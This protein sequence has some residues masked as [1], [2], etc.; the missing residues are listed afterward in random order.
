M[1]RKILNISS[2]VLLAAFIGVS[3]WFAETRMRQQTFKALQVIVAD[4]LEARFILPTDVTG[5]LANRGIRITGTPVESLNRDQVRQTVK[6]VTGVKDALVYCTPGGTLFITVWQRK[7]VLRYIGPYESFYIDTE[8]KEMA[9]SDKY[10]AKVMTVTG[11]ADHKFL[12][13]SL[14]RVVRYISGETFLDALIT[15][16]QVY[17]DHT[18]EI[19][20][21]IG[22]NRIFMGD[23]GDYEWKLAKLRAFYRQ[24]LPNV[25]WD[26]YSRIDLA[27]S[28]Q[29][30]ARLWTQEQRKERDSLRSVRDTL[31]EG[32]RM[33]E[34]GES[35]IQEL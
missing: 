21:R 23:A 8:G 15:E 13:D 5:I 4:S 18:L 2:W 35:I 25:G 10:T 28:N 26:K 1:W 17:P 14:F 30:V 9:L 24:G 31:G 34:D 16:I 11:A 32:E 22:D 20:P 12:A 19:I 3:V 33:K 7:P 6:T 27:Y 29:V